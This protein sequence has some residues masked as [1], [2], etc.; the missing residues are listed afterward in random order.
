[1]FFAP[2]CGY[3]FRPTG[4]PVGIAIDSLA[5]PLF[6]STSVEKGFEADFTRVLREEFASHG[7]VPLVSEETAQ[8]LL[9]GRVY[10]IWTEP[11]SYSYQEQNDPGSHQCL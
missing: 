7:K 5:I 11:V 10:D 4:E 3:H 8:Y 9:T 1:M 6:K 2:G